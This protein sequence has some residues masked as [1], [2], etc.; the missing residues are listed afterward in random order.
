MC[1]AGVAPPLTCVGA[2]GECT[3]G[4]CPLAV[5]ALA[6]GAVE[7]LN[8]AVAITTDWGC[9]WKVRFQVQGVG[10]LGGWSG[11]VRRSLIV[12]LSWLRL[13]VLVDWSTPGFFDDEGR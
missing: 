12:D 13:S 10:N 8:L 1:G 3:G 11:V 9:G 5:A 2:V 7:T 4:A 6:D